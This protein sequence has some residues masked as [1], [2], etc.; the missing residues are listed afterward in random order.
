[1]TRNPTDLDLLLSVTSNRA[2]ADL[3]TPPSAFRPVSLLVNASTELFGAIEV[4]C[5]AVFEYD[6]REGYR[7]K[8]VL[9]VPL[10]IPEE[11]GGVTHI[12]SVQ[13]SRRD[14]DQVD[15]QIIVMESDDS[16]SLAHAISFT[17][18]VELSL[19]SVKG[20]VDK[21]RLISTR[22]LA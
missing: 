3:G 10:M 22:M 18:T 20:L 1:M 21:A 17:S 12:E 19:R 9:P 13:F 11:D 15:Y 5:Q 8:L 7:S 6:Q 2:S 16:E 4:S 14:N